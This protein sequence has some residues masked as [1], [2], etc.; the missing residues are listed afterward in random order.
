MRQ[1]LGAPVRE[2]GLPDVLRLWVRY[3]EDALAG[4]LDHVPMGRKPLVIEGRQTR[5]VIRLLSGPDESSL[6]L[7]RLRTVIPPAVLA[8]R[9]D[10]TAR[11]AEILGLGRTGKE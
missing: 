9:F 10:P 5:L 7:E 11:E 1:H 2:H 8:S 6:V 4:G 3:Q